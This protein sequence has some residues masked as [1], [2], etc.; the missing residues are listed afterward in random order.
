MYGEITAGLASIKTISDLT[1]LIIKSKVSDAVREHAIELQSQIISLQSAVLGLQSQYQALLAEKDELKKQ[2]IGLENWEAEAR[3]YEL[4]E[5]APSVFAYAI[6]PEEDSSTPVHWLCANCFQNK[7]KSILQSKGMTVN[8]TDYHCARC[9]TSFHD[10]VH[11]IS[12][13]IS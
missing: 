11:R 12:M 2:L 8:G 1:S 7:Q 5:I 13:V 3:N 6:Q 4:I 9:K 10:P